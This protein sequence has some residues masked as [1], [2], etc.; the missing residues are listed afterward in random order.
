LKGKSI[1]VE[2]DLS[3]K[4]RNVQNNLWAREQREKRL[5]MKVGLGKVKVK[6]VWRA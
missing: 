1:F 2:K 4:E 3:W 5:E 6:G